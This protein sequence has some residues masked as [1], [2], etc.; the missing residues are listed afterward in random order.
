MPLVQ[1]VKDTL[2]SGG[3]N[4]ICTTYPFDTCYLTLF[5]CEILFSSLSGLVDVLYK[6]GNVPFVP[7]TVF[8][9]L[10]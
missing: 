4:Y 2:V 10:T 6:A 9:M 5:L 3:N 7:K 8:V 1:P